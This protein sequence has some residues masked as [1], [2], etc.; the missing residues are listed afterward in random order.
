MIKIN[1]KNLKVTAVMALVAF[2]LT[3]DLRI[4]LI[5]A[6]VNVGADMFLF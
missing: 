1:T 5:L 2:L 3:R 4:T 6:G